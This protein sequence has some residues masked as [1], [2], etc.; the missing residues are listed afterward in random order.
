MLLRIVKNG[1]TGRKWINFY[2]PISSSTSLQLG[3]KWI[4][5]YPKS[6]ISIKTGMKLLL[7]M[8]SDLY[9]YHPEQFDLHQDLEHLNLHQDPAGCV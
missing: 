4:P 2:H 6:C 9:I 8:N 5:E 1:W 3:Y 7:N